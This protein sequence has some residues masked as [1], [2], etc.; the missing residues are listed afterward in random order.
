MAVTVV[1]VVEFLSSNTGLGFVATRALANQDLPLMFAA[2]FVAIGI[3]LLFNSLIDCS[4]PRHPAC[5]ETK[6][7][8][9]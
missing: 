2:I 5:D 1:I 7:E 3:G 9:A 8:E 4:P 6:Y